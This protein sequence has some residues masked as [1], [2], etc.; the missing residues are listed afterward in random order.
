MS[1]VT[2]SKLNPG[3]R[4]E[5]FL[6][7]RSAEQRLGKGGNYLDLILVDRT[8]EIGAKVWDGTAAPPPAGSVIKVRGVVQ[9]FNGRLQFRVEKFRAA[10]SDDQVDLNSLVPCAPRSPEAMR[11]EIDETVERLASE[12]LRKLV[13]E[14]LDQAG[15]R[16]A[17]FPAAQ[18][19]HHA[20]RSGLL[21]HTTDMLRAAEQ[22][23]RAYPAL[24]GDLLRAGVIL[25]DLA[26]LDEM[27]SDELGNVSDYTRDGLL[28]GHI[29]R[30]MS[31]LDEAARKT[32]VGG[33]L[34]QLLEHMI[35]SHHGQPEYGSPRLPMFPEAQVLHTL[36][37]L[38][39]KLNEMM[40][41]LER[42]P[43]G[44]FSER[45][46]SLDGRRLYHPFY[47]DSAQ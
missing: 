3:D 31:R 35:L 13:R 10:R 11:R 20:E 37:N 46:P 4:M 36:D 9:E 40:T 32:G 14:M 23:I 28:V 1:E 47:T 8:G 38:D 39:A 7:V 33:E 25:H 5:G 22:L 12:P 45:I 24:N 42:T 44:S 16:L 21:H 6:L 30:G 26:K 41:I 19:M 17:W 18:R 43:E 34:V 2:V 27:K 29:A 15:D